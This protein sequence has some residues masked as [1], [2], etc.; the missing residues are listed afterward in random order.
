M[1]SKLSLH[2]LHN[3]EQNMVRGSE[4]DIFSTGSWPSD[5]ELEASYRE[6]SVDSES[7]AEALECIDGTIGNTDDESWDESPREQG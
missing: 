7:K 1:A 4:G 3:L 5:E 6:Q 2:C